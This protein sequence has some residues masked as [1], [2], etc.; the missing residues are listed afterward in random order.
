MAAQDLQSNEHRASP[1]QK[2]GI[3][4]WVIDPEND[5]EYPCLILDATRNGCRIYCDSI[6]Q[7]PDNV[8]LLPDGL[9]EPVVAKVCWRKQM[10]AGLS[11]D[12]GDSQ[13]S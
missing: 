10:L 5:K 13:P 8:R 4:A 3:Q 1:R 9:K 11:I 6:E 12:W 7:V 2:T